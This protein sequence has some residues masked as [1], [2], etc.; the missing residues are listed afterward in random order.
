MF[1]ARLIV[2]RLKDYYCDA[3]DKDDV[4]DD[5]GDDPYTQKVQKNTMF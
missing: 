1:C 3:D 4:D 2:W 5:V